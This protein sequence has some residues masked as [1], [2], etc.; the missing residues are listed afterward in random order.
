MKTKKR[1]KSTRSRGTHTHGRGFKKKARGSG[2]RGGVGNAGSGKRADQ[3]KNLAIKRTKKGYFGKNKTLRMPVKLKTQSIT[4]SQL[5][6]KLNTLLKKGTAKKSKTGIEVDLS[7]YKV[8]GNSEVKEKLTIKAKSVT[9]SA[10]NSIEKAG[11]KLIL[12]DKQEK[13]LK[14][15]SAQTK[16]EKNQE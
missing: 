15:E 5:S 9:K 10:K 16:E 13:S 1:K 11:G 12:P 14:K 2:H 4:L 6:E 8:F 3:K 7:Q